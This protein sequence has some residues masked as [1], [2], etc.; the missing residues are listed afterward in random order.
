MN[1]FEVA[2]EIA[3][4]IPVKEVYNDMAKP[5]SKSTGEL[6]GLIPRAI[7]GALEPLHKWILQKE[8][9]IEQTKLLLQIKLENIKPEDI[10]QPEAYIAIPAIQ[11]ISYCVDSG[12]LRNMYANLLASS[13]NTMI[14]DNVH[15]SFVEIIKQLSPDEAKLLKFL[16][17]K[18]L[19]K[20][21]IDILEKKSNKEGEFVYFSNLSILGWDAKC[22]FPENT[23]IYINNL[24]RLGIAEI[25][26][27]GYLVDDFRYDKI[28]ESQAFAKIL[29]E[30]PEENKYNIRK[31]MFGISDFG[32]S[33]RNI[34]IG[35][36][37]LK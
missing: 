8:Y 10:V 36:S 13:M 20:P 1:E 24:C 21:I 26:A 28:L 5:V 30:A 29:E 15:P 27:S 37:L 6:V 32:V 23:P 34:C 33:F 19:C 14:K 31:K 2:K 3:K 4:Q 22:D 11:A 35:G 12:E 16:P 7:N 25:P 9:S 17:S 18:G